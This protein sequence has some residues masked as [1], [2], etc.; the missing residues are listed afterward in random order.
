MFRH[1]REAFIRLFYPAACEVC[2][3]NLDLEEKILCQQ[4]A[5]SL[6]SLAWP[7]EKA[8]AEERFEH[9]DHVWT[10]YAYGS[11]VRELLHGVKY[12]RK[13]YLLKACQKHAIGL[14]QAVTSDFW[15]DA[16]LP[17]PIDR[18]KLIKRHFNQAEIF[19]TLLEPWLT[20]P[21]DRSLLIKHRSIPSQ[22]SLSQCERAI[23]V[24][25]SF[26]LK[27][28]AKVLGRSFLLLDDVLTTGATANEAARLLKLHG[29]KRVDCMTLAKTVPHV[30]KMHFPASPPGLP[31]D[32]ER[33]IARPI[34]KTV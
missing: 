6:D 2:R 9:L 19:A 23:N 25:G 4:C 12:A 3:I 22:T 17:I 24:Y 10:V 1:Y 14:A 5:G 32:E 28:R 33:T 31:K 27:C 16:I 20:P 29:A 13:D 8:M 7:M 26:R 30:E 11:P 34:I 21:V 15:Y 18:M